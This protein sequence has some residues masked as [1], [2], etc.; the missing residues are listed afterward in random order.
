MARTMIQIGAG[1]FGGSWCSRFIP[2]NVAD[3]TVEVVAAVDIDPDVLAN[4]REHLHLPEAKC[5]TDLDKALDENPADFCTIVV[6]PAHHEAVADA[7]LARRLNILSE[8]PIADTLAGSIRIADKARAAGVK[9]GITM[10]HRF[11][12]DITTLRTLVQSGDYGPLDYLVSRYIQESRVSPTWGAF[13]YE[14]PD[15]LMVEG[16]VHHLDLLAD[17]AGG[18]CETIYAQTWNPA[19]SDFA[20]DS[21]ALVTMHLASGSRAT[22]EG[23]NAN[24]VTLNGW[25]GEYIRAEC[26]DATFVMSQG[27]IERFDYDP[28]RR[29]PNRPEGTGEPVPL[30]EQPKWA[31][32]WLIEKYVRWLDGGEA[33]ETN[34]D[35]SLQSIALIFAAIESGRTGQ[36]V[37]VQEFLQAAR[38]GR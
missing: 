32:A 31:N 26:R 19:W 12:Q 14:I 23:A 7:V 13:R 35:D 2:P 1:G 18:P 34:V 3:G 9:M 37:R 16:S 25:G 21:Q 33:M 6:P 24:A 38:E 20:G 10:S 17:M 30:L 15:P 4:A 36:P 27:K 8:K 28:E 11:R 29:D 5:Y 22:Y